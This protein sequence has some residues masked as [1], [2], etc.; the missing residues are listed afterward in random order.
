MNTY[1]IDMNTKL[2]AVY[3]N[4]EKPNL[5]RVYVDVTLY[6]LKDQLDQIKS[7]QRNKKGGHC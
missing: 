3:Y 4:R 5:L 1:S 7:P 6:G 2:P